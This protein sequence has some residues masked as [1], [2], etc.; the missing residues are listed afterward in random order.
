MYRVPY[1]LFASPR[2]LV[3]CCV[4]GEERVY[5]MVVD[6]HGGMIVIFG[7][8]NSDSFLIHIEQSVDVGV[9][10]TLL[11]TYCQSKVSSRQRGR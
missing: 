1:Y 4:H 10:L 7:R 11:I 5:N 9:K 8:L 3:V 2:N 6:V